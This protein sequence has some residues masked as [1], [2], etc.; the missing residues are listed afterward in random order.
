M[1]KINKIELF[2]FFMSKYVYVII[3]KWTISKYDL[4][5]GIMAYNYT[6]TVY[7]YR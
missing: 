2:L 3:S 1:I 6:Q 4:M 7:N 5:T